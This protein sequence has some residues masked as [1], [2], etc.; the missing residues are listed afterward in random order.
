MNLLARRSFTLAFLSVL[1]ASCGP[2]GDGVDLVLH[3]GTVVTVDSDMP[4]A[5]AIAIDGDTIV[6]V[7]SNDDIQEFIG[8]MTQVI[9]LQGRLAIPGFVEGHGHF[10]SLGK[11]RLTLPLEQAATWDA[12][13]EMVA[14]AAGDISA[15]V[16]IQGRGWHQEKWDDLPD[17]VVEGVPTHHDLSRVAPNNPV[18]L[19][20]ASGHGSLAN[21]RAMELAGIDRDTPDPPGG[22]IVRDDEG[23]PT[24]YLR[25]KAQQLAT[26][27][28]GEWE[29]SR[30][31]ELR[32]AEIA[33]AV[34]LAGDDLI[35][36]GITSFQ[37]A[38]TSF[39][40]L[41]IFMALAEASELPVR[42]YV[43]V[44]DSN[45][46]LVEKLA[47]YRVIDGYGGFLTVRTVKR[48]VDGALGS[49]GA[50][51]LEPYEDLPTSGLA[52]TESGL[53]HRDRRNRRRQRLSDGDPRHRRSRQSGSVEHLR[54]HPG[55]QRQPRGPPLADRARPAS[56][57]RRHSALRASGSHRL[58][59]G[60]PL[61]RRTAHGCA[62][63][64]GRSG[65]G[66][67]PT[68]GATS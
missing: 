60:R 26:V 63:G 9:D 42:L 8:R 27:A 32:T 34:S 33:R 43:M 12:M 55:G 30:P 57:P 67:A 25:E 46:Y 51:L 35:T 68:S 29:Q 61:Q 58:D 62:S 50:W 17:M 4:E 5:Q 10:L 54:D 41:D 38:G 28:R 2:E 13:V 11:A 6:A 53:L 39:D 66:R 36:K 52:T 47:D 21:A 16:W 24:G 1:L 15:D 18:I 19:R 22:T 48:T 45:H 49:H 14:F 59:A 7:G 31:E 64:W 23:E 20:H 3:N 65:P 44:R 37:D 40:T 56:A